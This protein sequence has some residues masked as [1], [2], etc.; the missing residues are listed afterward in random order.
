MKDKEKSEIFE[1]FNNN[2]SG[3]RKHLM[4]KVKLLYT[5]FKNIENALLFILCFL[6]VFKI[7]NVATTLGYIPTVTTI[8]RTSDR[9]FTTI[10]SS[11]RSD[12]KNKEIKDN[13]LKKYN[14]LNEVESDLNIHVLK[15]YYLPEGFNLKNIEVIENHDANK[16]RISVLY[17]STDNKGITFHIYIHQTTKD[18]PILVSEKIAKAPEEY[19][20]NDI[21]YYIYPNVD[22]Y[23]ISFTY[24]NLEYTISGIFSRDEAI[25]VI[26][27]LS[28]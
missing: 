18:D 3:F 21:I 26:Q 4:D 14:S 28:L 6:I 15:P 20:Y 19:T 10:L 8:F 17:S 23:S 11:R 22:W 16:T 24:L 2:I 25:K 7:Y 13:T 12:D 5:V 1:I 27:G 9:I